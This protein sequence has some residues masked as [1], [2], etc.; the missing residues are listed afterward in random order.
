VGGAGKWL[1]IDI[2]LIELIATCHILVA[3]HRRYKEASRS[4]RAVHDI[5]R[6]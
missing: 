3:V 2:E 4:H 5:L 1:C 6:A